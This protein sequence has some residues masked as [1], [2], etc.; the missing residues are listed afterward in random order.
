MKVIQYGVGDLGQT[1]IRLMAKK[2]YEVVAAIG[3]KR[4]LNEDIGDISGLGRKLGV[5]VTGDAES[6]LGKVEADVVCHMT[7]TDFEEVYREIMPCVEAGLNVV[8]ISEELSYPWDTH[9]RLAREMDKKAKSRRVTVVGTGMSP[10]WEHDL[11]PLTVASACARVDSMKVMRVSDWSHQAR[12]RGDVRF[13]RSLPD[14]EAGV[15]NG[16]IPL[17]AGFPEGLHMVATALGWK[18]DSIIDW[19]EPL[20]SKSLRQGPVYTIKAGQTCGFKHV[21]IGL[22]DGEAKLTFGLTGV[23]NPVPEEDGE[24]GTFIE[25]AGEPNITVKEAGSD[26]PL[27]TVARAVNSLKAGVEARPGLLSVL[28]LPVAPP[29]PDRSHV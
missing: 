6:V 24:M 12:S 8:S 19:W 1:A 27:G 21:S 26:V 20:V 10:G 3:R 4:F 16:Q 23:A 15:R 25:I 9:T 13:G 22:I 29:L 2:G 14:F 11:L 28:D 18:L 7:V 5:K 17:H